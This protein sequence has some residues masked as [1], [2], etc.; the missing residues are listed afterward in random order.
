[1]VDIKYFLRLKMEVHLILQL[2]WF[3]T[4]EVDKEYLEVLLII[5]LSYATGEEGDDDDV[6]EASVVIPKGGKKWRR[7]LFVAKRNNLE[8]SPLQNRKTMVRL[9]YF[10]CLENV[11]ALLFEMI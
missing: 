3:S 5:N 8:S 10:F 7:T 2:I 4:E 11:T 1:M 9:C 6:I